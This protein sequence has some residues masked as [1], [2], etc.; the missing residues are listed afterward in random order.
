MTLILG[1]LQP[2]K[3][4]FVVGDGR[5]VLDPPTGECGHGGTVAS[6]TQLKTGRGK[7]LFV[8][9]SSGRLDDV[10]EVACRFAQADAFESAI[11]TFAGYSIESG[12]SFG[13]VLVSPTR[14]AKLDS[15][16]ARLYNA[17]PG[18]PT[19][20]DYKQL[21]Y[22]LGFDTYSPGWKDGLWR[23]LCA[24]GTEN[25]GRL[26]WARCELVGVGMGARHLR[27]PRQSGLKLNWLRST[28]DALM[29]AEDLIAGIRCPGV[30]SPFSAA[31]ATEDE[32]VSLPIAEAESYAKG[33]DRAG[34]RFWLPG[35]RAHN[36]L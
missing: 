28:Y 5:S 35:K 18:S 34:K 21:A 12:R 4:G 31:F 24:R 10:K 17:E 3:V 11:E 22:D 2:T 26:P 14:L 6:E 32:V 15:G 13:T 9:G 16:L 19:E 23:S 33:I 1:I 29:F 25:L 7:G 20:R 36:Y 8:F 30:G 27:I